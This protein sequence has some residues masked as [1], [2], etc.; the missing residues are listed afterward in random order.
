M[1]PCTCCS[2]H[3][4]DIAIFLQQTVYVKMMIFGLSDIVLAKRV[5]EH[6]ANDSSCIL[7]VV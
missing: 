7:Y 4:Y 3:S 2:V 5:I 1:V 6:A